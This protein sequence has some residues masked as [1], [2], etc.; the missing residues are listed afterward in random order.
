LISGLI[1]ERKEEYPQLR[2]FPGRKRD[3]LWVWRK[4]S[5][6]IHRTFQ[7]NSRS[8]NVFIYLKYL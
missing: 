5:E 7:L 8:A 2:S 4:G 3:T 1:Q 6:V